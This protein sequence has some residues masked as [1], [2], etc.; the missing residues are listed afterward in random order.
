MYGLILDT[1]S[2]TSFLILTKEGKVIDL[3]TLSQNTKISAPILE[4][5]SSWQKK[6]FL[7]SKN[8]SYLAIGTGPGSFTGSKVGIT[9]GKSFAYAHQ[10]PLISFCSLISLT[11]D[12]AGPFSLIS[13]A[14]SSGIFVLEGKKDKEGVSFF[15]PHKTILLEKTPLIL[16]KNS[17]WISHVK[18]DLETKIFFSPLNWEKKEPNYP[19]LA[20]YLYEKFQKKENSFSF[21]SPLYAPLSCEKGRD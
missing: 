18:E 20:A 1:A 13:D 6:Y 14:K 3:F 12:K 17:L 10:I 7:S 21:F 16:E 8:V 19:F 11:P 9:I 15:F 2:L 5:L 4:T